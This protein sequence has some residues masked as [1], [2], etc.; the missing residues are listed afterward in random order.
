MHVRLRELKTIPT[1]AVNLKL[2]LC[3]SELFRQFGFVFLFF[4]HEHWPVHL[5]V[6][7]HGGDAKFVWDG[8]GF[9][10]TEKHNLKKGDL[11]RITR[12]V[13][14]NSDL[15]LARWHELFGPWDDEYDNYEEDYENLV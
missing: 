9:C 13:H 1:F 7:G 6:R 3:M 4:S 5:H 14:E 12:A 2:Q 11:E 8:D 10:L 15:I